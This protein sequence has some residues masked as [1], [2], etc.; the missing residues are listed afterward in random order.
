VGKSDVAA[1]LMDSFRD[2]GQKACLISADSVQVYRGLDIGSNKPSKAEQE[3]WPIELIDWL[4]P[5][6]PC[7]AGTWTREALRSIDT[8]VGKGCVPIV[9]G[10]SC[11]YLD[12]LVKGEPD[13][14]KSDPEVQAQI[15]EELRPF[16]DAM[17]WD[18]ALSLLASVDPIKADRIMPNNWRQL[19]R[20]L[21]VARSPPRQTG[22]GSR[23]RYDFRAIFLSPHDRP[24]LFH[25]IDRRCVAML[26]KGFLEEVATLLEKGLISL[27]TPAADAIGYR[28]VIEYLTR[29]E[30]QYGDAASLVEFVRKFGSVSRNYARSQM[31]WFMKDTAFVWVETDPRNP[32][33]TG[34]EVSR[35]CGLDEF[36]YASEAEVDGE[37]RQKQAEQASAMAWTFT[38]ALEQGEVLTA[39]ELSELLPRAD[40]CTRRVPSAAKQQPQKIRAIAVESKVPYGKVY[41]PGRHRKWGWGNPLGKLHRQGLQLFQSSGWQAIGESDDSVVPAFCWPTRQAGKFPATVSGGDILPLIRPFPQDFTMRLDNK[42]CMTSASSDECQTGSPWVHVI[43]REAFATPA[44]TTSWVPTTRATGAR[45]TKTATSKSERSA[46]SEGA[47]GWQVPGATAPTVCYRF[48]EYGHVLCR[49]GSMAAPAS[50]NNPEVQGWTQTSGQR[51]RGGHCRPYSCGQIR[52][53]RS[54]DGQFP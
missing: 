51:C 19:S 20:Q 37:V 23:D 13:A 38:S 46:R 43:L 9:V 14:A 48:A 27:D 8:A 17:D 44:S 29:P 42:V 3:R 53:C 15:S 31:H 22:R 28:Q 35:L 54:A 24:A 30:P 16:Q 18:G 49:P 50:S 45:W 52:R 7:T 32:A 40:N 36:D 12:W 2:Q 4:E 33:L 47:V 41:W 6:R 10:G 1:A 21:E 25:R 5:D 11:M 39:Q 34:V 26:Q